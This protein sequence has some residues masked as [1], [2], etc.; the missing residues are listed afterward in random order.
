MSRWLSLTLLVTLTL[1]AVAQGCG[2]DAGYQ[3][4]AA[5]AARR[6]ERAGRQARERALADVAPK[7]VV[8]AVVVAALTM[9]GAG[10]AEAMRR[11]VADALGIGPEAQASLAWKAFAAA[12]AV[13]LL[14]CL[15]RYGAGMSAP[16]FIMAAAALRPVSGYAS[17]VRRGD[18]ASARTELGRLKTLGVSAL[19]VMAVYELL[20]EKGL[21]GIGIK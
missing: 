7:L 17:A 6:I 8:W 21:M 9:F 10:L 3:N 12:C 16:V 2:Y 18:S 4:G 13:T 19:V 14:F 5:D 20:S 11:G 15:G 1:L